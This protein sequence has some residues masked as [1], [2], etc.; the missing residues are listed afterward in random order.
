MAKITIIRTPFVYP[1]KHLSSITAVPDI[2]TAYIS[3]ALQSVGHET[4]IIDCPG[5]DMHR[6][7]QVPEVDLSI[8]GLRADEVIER[9]P[10]DTD[11]IGLQSMHSNRW[12]Y[13][14]V[15]ITAILQSFPG[16]PILLGGEHIT[17]TYE[18]VL[19][20][21]PEVTCCVLGEGEE[22][23][24]EVVKAIEE[25]SAIDKITGIAFMRNGHLVETGRRVRRKALDDLP[26][27][28]WD[29]VPIDKY[30][31]NN[32][33]INS[34]SRKSI[35]MVATRG[36]PHTC[37][38]CTVPNMWDS[39]WFARPATDVVD[40]I[41]TYVACYGVN[42]IDFVD[43]TIVVTK[44]WMEEF[45]D[46][47][48]AAN[49][50]LTWAIPIGTRTE[51]IDEELL[52][53]M[54][55]SG[56]T[57]VLYS[58][59]SGSEETLQRIQK[60]LNVT[61]FEKVVYETA[62]LDII[63]KVAFIFGFPGQTQKEVW[64]SFK[65]VNR[66]ALLGAHDIVC[67]SF[68]PYP[69]TQLFDELDMDYDYRDPHNTIRLNND[70]PRMKSWSDNL[71]D[72]QVKFIVLFFTLYF[73]GLQYIL[74][75]K[76]IFGSIKRLAV[77]KKPLTNFESILFNFFKK[78]TGG[79]LEKQPFILPMPIRKDYRLKKEKLSEEKA[80]VSA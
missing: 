65:L 31:E 53:K 12:V 54:K 6:Y 61:N 57:R 14:Q 32:C 3:G 69:K 42:H 28:S 47:L 49:L 43:L 7:T 55:K 4:T 2:G 27:P 52:I 75:P 5:E 67:L 8:N 58:A 51:K 20:Q 73:Y 25:D 59:E 74:R 26:R 37:T 10:E 17:A 78:R 41:K 33:G 66:I 80:H 79:K 13:D 22:T 44:K 64:D 21:F 48:I 15:I 9:I 29:G 76:R 23:V 40:E 19:A 68:I 35:T 77:L 36:C 34:L 50:D 46:E 39:K 16:I 1:G 63:V 45:C 38:F 11:I 18:K 62:R 56:L 71:T 72:G 24:I 70:I 60:R 30:L